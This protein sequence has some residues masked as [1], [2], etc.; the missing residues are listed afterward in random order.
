MD[1]DFF[2]TKAAKKHEVFF[3]P[4]ASSPWD[5]R[6]LA[7]G[8]RIPEAGLARRV[9]QIFTDFVSHRDHSGHR[10]FIF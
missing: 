5:G 6:D 10:E 7:K 1:T 2:T 4:S 8:G 9:A 3:Q